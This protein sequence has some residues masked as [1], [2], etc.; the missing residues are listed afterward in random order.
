MFASEAVSTIIP[1]V[2]PV[3]E[4]HMLTWHPYDTILNPDSMPVNPPAGIV[5]GELLYVMAALN[6]EPLADGP[7]WTTMIPPAGWTTVMT[8]SAPSGGIAIIIFSKIA[9]GTE[10]VATVA[11]NETQKALNMCA[12][13]CRISG[14]NAATPINATGA[15]A[16]AIGATTVTAQPFPAGTAAAPLNIALFTS[17]KWASDLN[18]AAGPYT[19]MARHAV[20]NGYVGLEVAFGTNAEVL[21]VAQNG[22]TVAAGNLSGIQVSIA[23]L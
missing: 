9:D 11:F 6:S 22:V 8:V 5:A 17:D 15:N 21:P 4:G 16:V 7:L 19:L 3:L 10:G 14:V 13:Y 12:Y 18:L 20:V 1:P 23:N 2:T